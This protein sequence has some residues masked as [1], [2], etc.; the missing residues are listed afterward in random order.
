M[1]VVEAE[2]LAVV[3]PMFLDSKKTTHVKYI[4]WNFNYFELVYI[5]TVGGEAAL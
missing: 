1:V 5:A 4:E 2:R 3:A